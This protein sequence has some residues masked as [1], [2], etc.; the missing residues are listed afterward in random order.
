MLYSVNITYP[1][2]WQNIAQKEEQAYEIS[3]KVGQYLAFMATSWHEILTWY[4]YKI[5]GIYPEYPSAFS[6]EDSYS[7]LLGTRIG[8]E[9][10][11]D[12]EHSYNK[13]VEIAIK[14]ELKNLGL[15]PGDAARRIANSVKRHCP[16]R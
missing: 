5:I 15:L 8:V 13:A 12:K 6:W 1:E 11:N 7:N 9:A 3:I 10:L 14:K 2:S 4:G 16:L